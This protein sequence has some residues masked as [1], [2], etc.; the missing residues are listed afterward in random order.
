MRY[1]TTAVNIPGIM[2]PGTA[3]SPHY[4]AGPGSGAGD[5]LL[6]LFRRPAKHVEGHQDACLKAIARPSLEP[7]TGYLA[8][9]TAYQQGN[10]THL[11]PPHTDQ[12]TGIGCC[13]VSR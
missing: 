2:P 4:V 11:P 6:A 12:I 5:S 7:W 3:R 8:A 10:A 13:R 9:A 1:S